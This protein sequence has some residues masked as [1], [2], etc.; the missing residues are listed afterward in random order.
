MAIFFTIKWV[1]QNDY[2]QMI[3]DSS[4]LVAILKAENDAGIYRDY[5]LSSDEE[6]YLSSAN[7]LETSIVVDG[8]KDALA[9]ERL[10]QLIAATN[11]KIVSFTPEH[12]QLARKA[13][14]QF[15]RGSGHP[16]QL[17]FGDCFAYALAISTDQPLL[18]KGDDFSK[19]DVKSVSS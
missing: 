12:A 11:I 17:N 8:L 1:C 7:Y 15:G 5:L 14:A 10:D 3:V 9:S 19:T 13:Y 2:F 16:A 4:A 6:K 18:F